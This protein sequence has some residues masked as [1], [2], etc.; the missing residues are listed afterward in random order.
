[1][2]IQ[3]HIGKLVWSGSGPRSV[4]THGHIPQK[5]TALWW[6]RSCLPEVIHTWASTRPFADT[7]VVLCKWKTLKTMANCAES[8]R[9]GINGKEVL[10]SWGT[11]P[12]TMSPLLWS[13]CN[14][15]K[16]CAHALTDVST[17]LEC[18]NPWRNFHVVERLIICLY[19][20][21]VMPFWDPSSESGKLYYSQR[22][23]LGYPTQLAITSP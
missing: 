10:E 18:Y 12:S 8:L 11:A 15:F 21:G 7:L 4:I 13:S 17:Y 9:A 20:D 22:E 2:K 16:T 19:F 14:A 1:M 3:S 23:I 5:M 6:P